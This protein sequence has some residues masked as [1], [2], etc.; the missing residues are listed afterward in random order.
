MQQGMGAG[1]LMLLLASPSAGLRCGGLDKSANNMVM[2][3]HNIV[4]HVR[5]CMCA[6]LFSPISLDHQPLLLSRPMIRQMKT[7]QKA[8]SAPNQPRGGGVER[9]V[10]ERQGA[11]AQSRAVIQVPFPINSNKLSLPPPPFGI[12]RH[13]DRHAVQ[14]EYCDAEPLGRE[15]P[16]LWNSS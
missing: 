16:R 6:R 13:T 9:Q 2:C 5:A 4:V 7:R 1:G 11:A 3:D 14:T 8:G 12:L 10:F 15:T